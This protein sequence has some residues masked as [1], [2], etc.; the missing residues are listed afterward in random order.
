MATKTIP[1]LNALGVALT[2]S[3]LLEISQTGSFK[4]TAQD[5]IDLAFANLPATAHAAGDFVLSTDGDFVVNADVAVTLTAQNGITIEAINGN[6]T[7]NSD[8]GNI[9]L[10]CGGDFNLSQVSG[11][12]TINPQGNIV[13]DTSAGD[14]NLTIILGAGNLSMNGQ[15]GVTATTD[16]GAQLNFVNGIFTGVV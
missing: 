14:R 15:T 2:T 7:I 3:A 11:D 5:L 12:A 9:F 4:I 10:G 16:V 6:L 1:Q 8:A 13:L